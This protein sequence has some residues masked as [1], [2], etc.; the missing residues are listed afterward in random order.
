MALSPNTVDVPGQTLVGY[1]RKPEGASEL[2]RRV[3]RAM[4]STRG[5]IGISLTATNYL[6][7]AVGFA[8]NFYLA[9]A[10]GAS[11][12]GILSYGIVLGTFIYT[13]INFGAERTLVRDLIHAEDRHA[14]LSAS[15]ILR[16][17]LSILT[18]AGMG[19]Y[20]S[21][22]PLTED[23]RLVL[24]FCTI[25][26]CFWASFPVAWF[27]AH[28]RMHVHAFITLSERVLFAATTYIYLRHSAEPQVGPVALILLASRALS[29][30]VQLHIAKRTLHFD[31]R[32]LR[33]N[34][35]WLLRGNV[36]IV[37]A[38][39]ANLLIS[40][41]NQ[42]SLEHQLSAERL[43][44]FALAF[45]IIAVV[46]LLQN[47]V[48]RL[49]F[50]RIANL[51]SLGADP[52]LATRKFWLY[53]L[54]GTAFSAIITIPVV[55]LAP[56]VLGSLFAPAYREALAP[57]RVLA[58]WA[59]FNGGARIVN[60]FLINLRLDHAFFW[61]A[62]TAGL[63]AVILGNILI[64]TLGEVGVAISLLASHPI[65]VLMQLVRVR[66][67]LRSRTAAWTAAP[68]PQRQA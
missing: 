49:F 66:A 16:G 41:W 60:A 44:I 3:I 68:D 6:Q 56:W 67:E 15:L 35:R 29:F 51:T 47:Q 4:R 10:L 1:V 43:G 48:L 28:Y 14:I 23:K 64:P 36:L 7:A 31:F 34:L 42:L 38:A 9:N 54:L 58:I 32:G 12:F 11:G 33:Q 52:R 2:F 53:T 46:T 25:A 21:A 19:A 22:F 17:T 57:L 18:I 59:V 55:A 39:T 30:A 62:L 65:S 61:S 26:A 8:A 45:Q 63:L 40:H 27:D 37:T 13:F 20:L 50:P 24:F 5:Q